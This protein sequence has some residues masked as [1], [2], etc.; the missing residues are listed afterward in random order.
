LDQIKAKLRDQ[1]EKLRTSLGIDEDSE[2]L[3]EKLNVSEN[4]RQC[5]DAYSMMHLML[6]YEKN[7]FKI[8]P[9]DKG[10]TGQHLIQAINDGGFT[11][12][13]KYLTVVSDQKEHS[14]IREIIFSLASTFDKAY[15]DIIQG[16]KALKKIADDI[17]DSNASTNEIKKSLSLAQNYESQLLALNKELDKLNDKQARLENENRSHYVTINKLDETVD[18]LKNDKEKIIIHKDSYDEKVLYGTVDKGVIHQHTFEYSNEDFICKDECV[19]Y[20]GINATTI[21]EGSKEEFV[22]LEFAGKKC[23]IQYFTPSHVYGRATLTLFS[24]KRFSIENKIEIAS[25]EGRIHYLKQEIETNEEELNRI[26]AQIKAIIDSQRAEIATKI[27]QQEKVVKLVE[28]LSETLNFHSKEH[29]KLENQRKEQKIKIA[30]AEDILLK[31]HEKF[32]MVMRLR[33]FYSSEIISN[34][35][36]NYFD[37]YPNEVDQL[38]GYTCNLAP[39]CVSELNDYINNQQAGGVNQSAETS[40]SASASSPVSKESDYVFHSAPVSEAQ[41]IDYEKLIKLLLKVKDIVQNVEDKDIVLVIG[42]TGVGKSTL[43]NYLNGGEMVFQENEE[44]G[45]TYVVNASA[46]DIHYFPKISHDGAETDYPLIYSN[47]NFHPFYICDTA[48]FSDNRSL[49]RRIVNEFAIRMLIRA[50]K[51]IKSVVVMINQHDLN[52]D[53]GNNLMLLLNILSDLFN[54]SINFNTSVKFVFN[55]VDK[56]IAQI[57]NII[58]KAISARPASQEIVMLKLINEQESL[59]TID[60]KNSDSRNE[61]LHFI[62][63]SIPIPLE[64]FKLTSYTRSIKEIKE[65]VSLIAASFFKFLASKSLEEE[66]LNT[67]NSEL[68]ITQNDIKNNQNILNDLDK[69]DSDTLDI[70]TIRTQ[71]DQLIADKDKE[72]K[73]WALFYSFL[74]TCNYN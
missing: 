8:D 4:D 72:I 11:D 45:D 31:Q 9:L 59:M 13:K 53:K 7:I 2:R 17:E 40:A 46:P 71:M 19:N 24:E 29:E 66:R 39:D 74:K 26:Q 70:E 68:E 57:K 55:K 50:A 18:K 69:P 43:I 20:E 30:N 38:K 32:Q 34:F 47:P 3:S 25:C 60:F 51:S 27:I 65:A 14:S 16:N 37:K 12:I 61:L 22:K 49:E 15:T 73:G 33:N 5:Y 44:T 36:K 41:Q 23:K 42:K 64:R 6:T 56:K 21:T 63:N 35:V 54:D 52:V 10:K 67:L 28:Q 58:T 1:L 48:G 62:E